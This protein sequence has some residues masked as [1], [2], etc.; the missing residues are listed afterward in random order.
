[1]ATSRLRQDV[2]PSPGP[3]AS[4]RREQCRCASGGACLLLLQVL[5]HLGGRDGPFADGRGDTLGRAAADIAS[6]EDAGK[7]GFQR[8]RRAWQV[9]AGRRISAGGHLASGSNEPVVVTTDPGREP[10]G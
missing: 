3:I 4:L 7:A 10:I 8:E 6:R 5:V 9:P 1:M 2:T